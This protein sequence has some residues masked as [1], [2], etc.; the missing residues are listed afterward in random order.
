MAEGKKTIVMRNVILE[1]KD[2]GTTDE[3]KLFFERHLVTLVVEAPG[4]LERNP[5]AYAAADAVML[6]YQGDMEETT[7]YIARLVAQLACPVVMICQTT[8]SE[9][10]EVR[11]LE[12]GAGDCLMPPFGLR[13]LLAR[14]RAR[15]RRLLIAR[16]R[17]LRV[18]YRFGSFGL[19]RESG[20]IVAA[21]AQV[22]LTKK[23]F[24]LLEHLAHNSCACVTREELLDVVSVNDFDVNDRSIDGIVSRL[25][26]RLVTLGGSPKLIRTVR[27][28]GYMLDNPVEAICADEDLRD[29]L[30]EFVAAHGN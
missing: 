26:E 17:T 6:Y 30:V 8:P 13:E 16:R 27:G 10:E 11:L 22:K 21:A 2:A 4:G 20:E 23:E 25:R 18:N 15:V 12:A 7:T 28:F 5:A 3:I 9:D 1:T 19:N 14:L 29:A 24:S